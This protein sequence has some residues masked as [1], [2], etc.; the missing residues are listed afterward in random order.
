MGIKVIFKFLFEQEKQTL[1]TLSTFDEVIIYKL[2]HKISKF[3]MDMNSQ[4]CIKLIPN[5]WHSN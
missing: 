5:Y 2:F 1:K 3:Y 4:S